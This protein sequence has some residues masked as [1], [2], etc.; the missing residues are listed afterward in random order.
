M[1]Y[2]SFSTHPP[3]FMTLKAL[4]NQLPALDNLEESASSEHEMLT[5]CVPE[6]RLDAVFLWPLHPKNK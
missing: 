5:V 2:L 6:V 1:G 4:I 3:P